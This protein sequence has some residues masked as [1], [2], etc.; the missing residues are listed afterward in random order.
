[1]NDYKFGNFI[2]ELRTE[3]GLSQSQLGD[4]LGVSNKAVSKWEMGASKPRPDMLVTLASLFNVT[5]DELLAGERNGET[6]KDNH[7]ENG[8]ATIKLW[9]GEYLKKKKRGNCAVIIAVFLPII[10]FI[11]V[12]VLADH[13]LTDKVFAPIVA[14]II[15][16]AE[17]IDI[18]LI[19]VFYCSARR[20]KRILYATYHEQTEEI[21]AILS[22]KK[23]KIPMSKREKLVYLISATI[24]LLCATSRLILL[25]FV[26]KKWILGIVD[27]VAII[28]M[29]LASICEIIVLAHYC[30]RAHKIRNQ[31]E[32]SE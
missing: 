28:I 15:I 5:V 13:N 20:L 2:Y 14:I 16:L 3:K 29:V 31:K 24:M 17:V 9:A 21:S 18:A 23:E 10:L 4:M 1:M 27:I 11:W 26:S 22:P 32:S 12:G 7:K 6:K 19:I 25:S 8:D 30:I